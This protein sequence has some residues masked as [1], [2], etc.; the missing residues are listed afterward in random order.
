MSIMQRFVG[1]VKS[2]FIPKAMY[3]RRNSTILMAILILLLESVVLAVPIRHYLLSHQ[4]ESLASYALYNVMNVPDDLPLAQE[5]QEAI[6]ASGYSVTKTDD[7]YA[8]TA[9]AVADTKAVV[10]KEIT[11]V[12]L[13]ITRHLHVILDLGNTITS[14]YS[15]STFTFTIENYPVNETTEQSFLLFQ[16]AQA[17]YY[18]EPYGVDALDLVHNENAIEFGS[19]VFY[20]SQDA[21]RTFALDQTSPQA[22]FTNIADHLANGLANYYAT[23]YQVYLVLYN[24]VFT[25][26]IA[27]II[28]FVFRGRSKLTNFKQYLNLLAVS[29]I[30]PEILTFAVLWFYIPL[31]NYYIA[32]VAIYYVVVLFVINRTPEDLLG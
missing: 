30:A 5:V 1:F 18:P 9:S 29:S 26:L 27:L 28:M 7:G 14:A 6:T 17:V 4:D 11:Y 22:M 3:R 24:V 10:T 15:A 21:G 20:Y 31:V 19:Y 13:G 32:L 16:S 2:L 23:M 8:L 12:T 25:L